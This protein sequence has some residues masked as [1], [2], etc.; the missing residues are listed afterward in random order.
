[1][2][3]VIALSGNAM[4]LAFDKGLKVGSFC[5]ITKPIKV[6]KFMYTSNLAVNFSEK[7]MAIVVMKEYAP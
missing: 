4:Q 2:T 1:M 5:Y 7:Q 3:P 6:A